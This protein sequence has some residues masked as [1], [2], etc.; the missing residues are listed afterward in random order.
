MTEHSA[1]GWPRLPSIED[2]HAALEA[3]RFVRAR[4]AHLPEAVSLGAILP[5]GSDPD[6]PGLRSFI[7]AL[8]GLTTSALLGCAELAGNDTE[9]E[10]QRWVLDYLDAAIEAVTFREI[11]DASD[12]AGT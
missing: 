1:W 8:T 4:V 9:A 2:P 6:L 5:T 7:D 10:A 12:T 3:L 11:G